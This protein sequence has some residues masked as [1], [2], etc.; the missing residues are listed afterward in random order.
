M[1]SSETGKLVNS[2]LSAGKANFTVVSELPWPPKV[3]IHMQMCREEQSAGSVDTATSL[4]ILLLN[5]GT[6]PIVV[7]TRGPQRF[8]VP[9]GPFQPEEAHLDSQPRVIDNTSRVSGFHILDAATGEMVMEPKK[10]APSGPLTGS[11]IDRRPKLEMLVTLMPGEPHTRR[12][13]VDSLIAG[14]PDGSYHV[15]MVPRGMWW[16]VGTSKEMADEGNDRV[17]QHLYSTR[18]PPLMLETDDFVEVVIH[19]GRARK[20]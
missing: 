10:Q 20:E 11:T 16:C 15:R 12:V 14:L 4:E 8:L 1:K 6:G 9:W 13:D 5:K 17:P 7:Q 19:N 2:K 3:E 18:T